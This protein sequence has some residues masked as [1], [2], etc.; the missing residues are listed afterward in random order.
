MRFSFLLS[1]LLF[2]S[3]SL[4]PKGGGR[5]ANCSKLEDLHPKNAAMC[6]VKTLVKSGKNKSLNKVVKSY[7]KMGLQSSDE[8]NVLFVGGGGKGEDIRWTYL[9][10]VDYYD[11][12][13]FRS[14]FVVVN[15]YN[16]RGPSVK[17]VFTKK[18]IQ[19]WL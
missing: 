5:L 15:T 16:K 10:G 4:L 7:E 11:F 12:K 13:V 2:S 19:K 8:Y 14:V 3:C 17:K 1:L 6:F 9:V 18:E